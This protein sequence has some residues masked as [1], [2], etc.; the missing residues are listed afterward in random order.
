VGAEVI[1]GMYERYLSGRSL[2]LPMPDLK[3]KPSA[4]YAPAPGAPHAVVVDIDGTVALMNGRSPYDMSRVHLDTPNHAVISAVRAMHAAGH[5]VVYCS[6]RTDDGRADTQAWLDRHVG[7]PYEGLYMRELGD[8]R[9]DSV[10]KEEIF[11][12]EIRGRYN[13]VGVFD[14]RAQVVRM[15]RA[16]GLTVFQVAEGNF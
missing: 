5:L 6:G 16:L 2:P 12:R 3:P 11:N 8:Q 9:R 10:V 1:R 13:V 14:D 7:V 4:A 15:W